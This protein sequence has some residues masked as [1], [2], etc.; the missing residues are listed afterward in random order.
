MLQRFTASSLPNVLLRAASAIFALALTTVLGPLLAAADPQF[1]RAQ[2]KLDGL[3]NGT[4]PP[5][6]EVVFTPAEIEGWTRV[7]AH[8]EVGDALREPHVSLETDTGSG[9]A[10]VDFLKMRQARGKDTN[11]LMA[12]ILEGERP[13]K[14]FLRIS[15]AGGRCTVYVTRVELSGGEISGALLDYLI[16]T[17]LLPLYPDVKLGEPFDLPLNMERIE[18]RP[19]G[20]RV[21]IR[22]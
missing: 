10:L 7:K 8:E 9:A 18:L 6:S 2:A 21:T 16:K 15:S 14:V 17:F 22:K 19:E 20:V 3:L 5:G 12:R 11:A 4:A 1:D 13:L